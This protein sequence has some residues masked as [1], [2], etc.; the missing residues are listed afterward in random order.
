MRLQGEHRL[1]TKY[2]QT[3]TSPTIDLRSPF[4]S[5]LHILPQGHDKAIKH[6]FYNTAATLF[7]VF[8]CS[9]AVAVYYILEAFLRPLLWAVLC[10][11]FLHPFKNTL[12]SITQSWLKNLR[13][14]GTPI[15]V[16]AAVMPFQVMDSVSETIGGF[17]LEHLHLIFIGLTTLAFAYLLYHFGPVSQ[18]F[19]FLQTTFYFIY[20]MLGYFS[21]FWVRL[22]F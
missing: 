7:V 20:D 4:E 22:H 17:F 13:E 14:S 5:V 2:K 11:T 6:A 16:G 8:A 15:V 19:V 1:T 10:G 3:M 18:I 12:T 21:A 9:A